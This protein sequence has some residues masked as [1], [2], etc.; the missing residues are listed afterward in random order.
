ML[1][2]ACRTAVMPGAMQDFWFNS[3]YFIARGYY[4]V[5]AV[6]T[7]DYASAYKNEKSKHFQSVNL[8]KKFSFLGGRG[9]YSP[10][11]T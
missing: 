9:H 4:C 5:E 3:R 6:K 11:W 8:P 2:Q 10:N 7:F 1:G